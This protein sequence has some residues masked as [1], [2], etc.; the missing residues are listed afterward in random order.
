MKKL[1]LTLILIVLVFAII[2]TCKNENTTGPDDQPVY[3]NEGTIGT[4]GG[5]VQ[6]TDPNSNIYGAFVNIP[7][8]ALN[9]NQT[10]K[11]SDATGTII[12]PNDTTAI[13]VHLEPA[14]IVFNKPVEIGLPFKKETGYENIRA[15]FIDTTK[16]EII[17]LP[18]LTIDEE[19][20]ILKTSTIHFSDFY[21]GKHGVFVDF[22][23][24]IV[25]SKLK[26]STRV[27]G[28]PG[29]ND[30]GLNGITIKPF[31]WPFGI[32][33]VKE[34]IDKGEGLFGGGY[35]ISYFKMV[36]RQDNW[37]YD[38]K[39]DEKILLVKR[40][41]SQYPGYGAEVYLKDFSGKPIVSFGKLDS[42]GREKWFNG[43]TLIFNL[44]HVID[45][46]KQYYVSLSWGLVGDEYASPKYSYFYTFTAFEKY[47]YLN[48]DLDVG[49]NFI[50]DADEPN[51]NP[52]V[53]ITQPVN[54]QH[55]NIGE[56][57][58]IK[59]NASDN[60]GS[61]ARVKFYVNGTY[62][63]YDSSSPYQYSWNTNGLSAGS[64]TLKATAVD[65]DNAETSTQI[66]VY[67]DSPANQSPTVSITQ[68]ANN[69]HYNIGENVTIK[70]NAS[71]TDG[72]VSRVKFYVNGNYKG[73]DTSSPYQYSWN[74]SGLSAG[75]YTLKATAVDNDNAETS[76][77][78]TVYLDEQSNSAPTASFT[79]SPT[80]GSTSTTFNFDASGS[81]DTED[82]SSSLQVRW[83]WDNNGNWDTNYSTTKTASH[84]Y[85]SE[86]TKT[87]R[88]EVKDTGSLTNITT[89]KITVNSSGGITYIINDDF[90]SY[91]LS[92]FP[93]SG[94]WNLIYNGYGT[95]YQYVSNT[96]SISGN[97][98]L[99][100]EGQTNW[101]AT[102]IKEFNDRPSVI[103]FEGY[104]RTK[105]LAS[106][107]MNYSEAHIGLYN[108]D[109][110]TWGKQ[111]AYVYFHYDGYI[112]FGASGISGTVLQT[113]IPDTWYKIKVRY[114]KDNKIGE[115]WI[116]DVLKASN[117]DLSGLS[118]T[119]SSIN[120]VGGNDTH[121]RSWFDDIK[122]W[123]EE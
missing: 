40:I 45:K 101:S 38:N 3:E 110:S 39:L 12:P 78:I 28:T 9:S 57:V 69:Q 74:T 118:G 13:V 54:N 80:S 47:V 14:G 68:P 37:F 67:L 35:V 99:Q 75:S 72:N 15:F 94:G 106:S 18:I 76:T 112:K 92:T 21:A 55:Y 27:Y 34:A 93:S 77:Q 30:Q 73:Y 122:V 2:F 103:Y 8:G 10:I 81:S 91:S 113:W 56:N 87:I 32:S 1:I 119:Y 29:G 36:L 111:Y 49:N 90:E 5:T 104:V 105:K 88:L 16:S 23:F 7:E 24:N 116:N 108:K 66:T 71:D 70:A 26:I 98:S 46:E 82:L 65:N 117:V 41:G 33:S 43:S 107:V 115:V 83:D 42:K 44:D 120:I 79:V 48:N 20:G 60:D 6:N 22:D 84:Q 11:I 89:R 86:G 96:T 31:S 61:I 52:T 58:T 97:K 123:Y 19:A 121:T 59:A 64:Y 50:N 62:K 85:S 53:S 51:N 100:L 17:Q 114:D 102:V 109:T 25:D 63:G 4:S 95:S